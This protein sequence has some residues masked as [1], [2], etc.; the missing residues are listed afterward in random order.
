[1][2]ASGLTLIPVSTSFILP[3]SMALA[4]AVGLLHSLRLRP[5]RQIAAGLGSARLSTQL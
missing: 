3:E 5:R 2:F 4:I 1:L